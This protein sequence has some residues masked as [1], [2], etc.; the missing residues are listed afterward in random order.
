MAKTFIAVLLKGVRMLFGI[1][2]L[3]YK[4]PHWFVLSSVVIEGHPEHL[5][6]ETLLK[7]VKPMLVGNLWHVPIR[8]IEQKLQQ[9]PL[10]KM[11]L[12]SV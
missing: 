9:N 1:A 6:R 7:D 4:N 11:Q 2:L 3:L 8:R 10:V 5:D 12:P